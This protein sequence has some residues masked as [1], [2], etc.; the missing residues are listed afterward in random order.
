ML[1][2][3]GG[4]PGWC[5][6][7]PGVSLTMETRQGVELR[8]DGRTLIGA[9]IRYGDVSPSHRERFE[10]GSLTV[11]PNLAPTLG[12]RTGR[13]LA[14]GDDVRVEDRADALI[15]AAH[16]PRTETADMALDGVRSGRYRG[17]S[18]EFIARRESR[19]ASGIRVVEAADLPGL[20]LVDHPSYP[21]SRVETR[22][23]SYRTRVPVGRQALYCSCSA[24]KTG[25]TASHVRFGRDAFAGVEDAGDVMA[26]AG[27]LNQ[28]VGMTLDGSLRL[29]RARDGSLRVGLDPLDTTHGRDLRD[30]VRVGV[31]VYARPVWDPDESDWT[32]EGDVAHVT[33]AVFRLVLVK[34]V[35]ADRARG[36]D[37]LEPVQEG[38]GGRRSARKRSGG[39]TG[40]VDA[41]GRDRRRMW[42]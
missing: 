23:G 21:G 30:L 4:S 29:S 38:T 42:L 3:N 10:P 2:G 6:D 11:S 7:A 18:V 26:V 34:P 25:S 40:R 41:F 28:T 22:R 24:R 19:D 39:V 9:A 5:P 27:G 16:L 12:H 35:Q 20:A 8:A 1:P 37:P 17:W 32:L 36:L 13:V 33:R 31:P 14:Y 15:V